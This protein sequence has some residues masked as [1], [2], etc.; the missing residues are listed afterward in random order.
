L[1]FVLY[2]CVLILCS[3]FDMDTPYFTVYI[4]YSL[5]SGI[6]YTGFTS[7]LIRRYHDHNFNNT[8]GFTTKHR[9]WVVF[10]TEIFNSMQE[11]KKRELFLKSGQGRAFVKKDIM[12]IYFPL[13]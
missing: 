1:F 9:P 3:M 13:I 6:F 2:G 10:Y 7:D 8:A 11:A 4:L 12:P 5:K